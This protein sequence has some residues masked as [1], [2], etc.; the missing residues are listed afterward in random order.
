MYVGITCYLCDGED[1]LYQCTVCKVIVC[2]GCM[3]D[4]DKTIHKNDIEV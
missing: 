3:E 4:H 1:F 2:E